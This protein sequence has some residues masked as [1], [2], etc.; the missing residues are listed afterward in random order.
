VFLK[1]KKKTPM[2][3][4][5]TKNK[6]VLKKKK[7]RGK[8]ENAASTSSGKKRFA[9]K[10]KSGVATNAAVR[11]ATGQEK[12]TLL[13]KK[14]AQERMVLKEHLKDLQRKKLSRVRGDEAKNERRQ[15]GKY[16][17]ELKKQQVAKHSAEIANVTSE[18]AQ[19]ALLNGNYG[20]VHARGAPQ[21]HRRKEQR[22]LLPPQTVGLPHGRSS[23]NPLPIPSNVSN[24]VNFLAQT[25][26]NSNMNNFSSSAASNADNN[27]INNAVTASLLV[28]SKAEQRKRQQLQQQQQ[29]R[30]NN[31]NNQRW[32]NNSNV[33][34]EDEWIDVDDDGAANA[35]NNNNFNNNNNNNNNWNRNNNN[36]S[37]NSD[38]DQLRQLF[39]GF[40]SRN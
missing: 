34:N 4:S 7:T 8:T 16:I 13:R 35:G 39:A 27:L 38:A 9:T 12:L 11:Q 17:K 23:N 31:S 6:R 37:G 15:M 10:K 20:N 30:Q 24:N 19:D 18:N 1:N 29:Q 2:R 25:I 36:N 21:V 26:R 40:G 28:Q 32:N 33:N 5:S 3:I 14:Q 22:Y